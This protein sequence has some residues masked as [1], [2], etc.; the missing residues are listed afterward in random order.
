[1]Y[2]KVFKPLFD[3]VLAFV[4]FVL[5]LPLFVIITFLLA[6]ANEGKPFFFQKR[7]GKNE[8][9]FSIIK[10]KTMNDRKDAQGNLLPDADRLTVVGNWVRRL[11]LDE[12]PQLLN[13]LKG[14]M[15]LIGP[16]PLLPQYLPLYDDFQ[17]RRHEIKPGITG[18]AQ[19]NGRNALDWQ[20]K[21]R[22]DVWYVDHVSFFTDLKIVYL[23]VKKVL[24]KEGI[25]QQGQATTEAFKG[26]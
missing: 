20:T 4:A 12:I 5:L 16:R 26:N 21:F 14:D 10:F 2:A 25:N 3:F 7:P 6:I 19:V 23:T 13:V 18:W 8:K 15:S 9:I 22:Y 11:S 1:M 17:R 24:K